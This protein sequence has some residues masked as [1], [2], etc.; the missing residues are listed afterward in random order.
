V[1]RRWRAVALVLLVIEIGGIVW[2]VLNP[3][4]ATPTGAVLRVSAF[5]LDLGAPSWMASTTGWE[6]LL[7]LA[8]FAP[9]GF[10]SSL[11]WGRV[12]VEA[13]VLT[14]FVVSA[15]L[16]VIQLVV[17]SGRSATLIDVSANTVGMFFGAVAAAVVLGLLSRHRPAS[18]A[19]API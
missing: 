18:R 6:Y 7:N 2:L 16:E 9:L 4:A 19:G 14:G 10:L 12:S 8:L 11:I 1:S 17:L 5:V 13:W 3:S 15:G